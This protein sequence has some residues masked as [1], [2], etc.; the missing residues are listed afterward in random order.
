M[1][2]FL[3]KCILEP[4]KKKCKSKP[5]TELHVKGHFTED[6]KEWQ[7]KHQRCTPTWMKPKKNRKTELNISVTE[8][9]RKAEITVVLVLQARAKLGDNKVNG[10]DRERHDQKIPTEKSTLLRGAFK[11]GDTGLY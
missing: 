2:S 8:E 4:M 11:N 9:G 1:L 6:R 7:K 10:R 5:L 3:V